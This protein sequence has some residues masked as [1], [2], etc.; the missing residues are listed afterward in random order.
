MA[1]A[2]I[3]TVLPLIT[4]KPDLTGKLLLAGTL[5]FSGS[6][7]ALCF[8]PKGN[9][10]RAIAGPMTPLGGLTLIVGWASLLT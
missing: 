4:P 2:V 9:A 7:Y 6:I 3:L 1:H 8:L 10:L 5:M